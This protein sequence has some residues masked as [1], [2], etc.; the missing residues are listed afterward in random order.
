MNTAL[1]SV[2][3]GAP[4]MTIS[5]TGFLAQGMDRWRQWGLDDRL[6]VDSVF[7]GPPLAL[8]QRCSLENV[9]LLMKG[10]G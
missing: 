3:K 2:I 8:T 4:G 6:K 10:E 1:S 5:T 9:L 7:A